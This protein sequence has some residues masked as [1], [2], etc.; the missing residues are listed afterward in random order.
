METAV[1]EEHAVVRKSGP[2]KGRGLF[3]T[4]DIR[5]GALVAE[6]TGERIST[7]YADTLKTKY[8][9]EVDADW[10]ID[11]SSRDNLAR[12][13]NHSCEPNSEAD[14]QEGR[15]YILASRDIAAGEEFTIDYGEE[16]FD[17]FI[18]P[19]GCLCT[20]CVKRSR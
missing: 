7:V 3:A 14:I 4:R 1:S 9:F 11:G 20:K 2:G 5:S 19:T 13:L 17:E 18:K 8:L 16:Y 12:Y 15:I 6:Y 10:T